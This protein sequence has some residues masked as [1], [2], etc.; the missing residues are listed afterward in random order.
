MECTIGSPA[1]CLDKNSQV[2]T[3]AASNTRP[4]Y[5]CDG[6]TRGN[7]ECDFRGDY[8]VYLNDPKTKEWSNKFI[9]KDPEN[10]PK[11]MTPINH[12]KYIGN[13][14]VNLNG[15][16][17]VDIVVDPSI[18]KEKLKSRSR[19]RSRGLSDL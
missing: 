11:G 19:K 3:V 13:T 14:Q 2:V 18:K 10:L 5:L 17:H 4:I 8:H 6:P 1:T 7:N 16:C 15:R 9:N 12:R